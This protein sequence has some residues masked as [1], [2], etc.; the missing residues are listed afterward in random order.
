MKSQLK[1]IKKIKN[2]IVGKLQEIKVVVVKH[3]AYNIY[4]DNARFGE[5]PKLFQKPFVKRKTKMK[6]RIRSRLMNTRT[7]LIGDSNKRL[8]KK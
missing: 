2:K 4:T 5:L 7:L 8:I 3:N 6:K 1:E